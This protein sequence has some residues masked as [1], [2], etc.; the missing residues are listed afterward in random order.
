MN[1]ES[2]SQGPGYSDAGAAAT[3]FSHIRSKDTKQKAPFR[4]RGAATTAWKHP[5]TGQ[6]GRWPQASPSPTFCQSSPCHLIS[7]CT[8]WALE[9]FPNSMVT[10][11]PPSVLRRPSPARALLA[12]GGASCRSRTP[13]TGTPRSAPLA[14]PRAVWIAPLHTGS[15]VAPSLLT[16]VL[17]G[18]GPPAPTSVQSSAAPAGQQPSPSF[19]V[20]PGAERS[21]PPPALHSPGPAHEPPTPQPPPTGH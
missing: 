20:C 19:W 16:A 6:A 12:V 13:P 5:R 14:W 11:E 1:F 2:F 18:P 17:G 8:C 10:T 3:Q 7:T 15:H 21:L 4:H 9:A